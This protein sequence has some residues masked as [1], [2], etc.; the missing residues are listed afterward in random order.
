MMLFLDG[1][2]SQRGRRGCYGECNVHSIAACG[3]PKTLKAENGTVG[4][5]I[6]L[7]MHRTPHF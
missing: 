2:A 6:K 1:R 7:A 3:Y 5:M 4:A